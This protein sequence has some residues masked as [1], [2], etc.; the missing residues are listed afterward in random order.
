[1]DYFER[2]LREFVD[3]IEVNGLVLIILVF[4]F[5]RRMNG[6]FLFLDKVFVMLC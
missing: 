6:K 2:N 5:D 3:M 4:F 1:M